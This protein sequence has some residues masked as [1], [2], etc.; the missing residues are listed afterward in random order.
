MPNLSRPSRRH[1]LRAG[2]V[3]LAATLVVVAGCDDDHDDGDHFDLGR[4]ELET[5]GNPRVIVAQWT[6]QTG[7][8]DANGQ[9]ISELVNYRQEGDG[10]IVPIRVGGPNSSLTARYFLPNGE[11]V[12]MGTLERGPEPIRDR[13][14]TEYEARYFPLNNST[15]VIAW[16]NIRHPDSTTGP[17]HWASIGG[18]EVRGI[19]HCDHIHFYPITAGTVDV[20]FAL[21]HIDHADGLT[22]P[23]RLRVQPAN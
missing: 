1:R 21:W 20:E 13:T 3:A 6:G 23:L 19:F 12:E 11:E 22:D 2:F 5:R 15:N 17:F 4:V 9:A 10:S 16:P 18:G 8:T 7:W 14:C